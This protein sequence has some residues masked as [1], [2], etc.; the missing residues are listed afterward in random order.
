M[1]KEQLNSFISGVFFK[2]KIQAE[3]VL[4]QNECLGTRPSVL[5]KTQRPDCQLQALAIWD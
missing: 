2:R 5:F 4:Y 1:D 3:F